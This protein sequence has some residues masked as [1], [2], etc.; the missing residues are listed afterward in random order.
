MHGRWV[1]NILIVSAASACQPRRAAPP[2]PASTIADSG[3]AAGLVS[4]VCLLPARDLWGFM[5]GQARL[6]PQI[7]GGVVDGWRLYQ[8]H[9]RSDLSRA[10]FREGDLITAVDGR[11]L[12]QPTLVPAVGDSKVVFTIQRGGR[13]VEVVCWLR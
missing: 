12:T 3:A 11:P 1:A 7:R 4:P 6:V 2:P 9:A 5:A 8:L 13:A 10:G